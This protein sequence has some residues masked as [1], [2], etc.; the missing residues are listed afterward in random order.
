M[1]PSPFLMSYGQSLA[2]LLTPMLLEM[3]V[4]FGVI[5]G[6]KDITLYGQMM[7]SSQNGKTSMML[8]VVALC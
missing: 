1:A 4:I 2:F 8:S 7:P 6:E 3:G 5:C